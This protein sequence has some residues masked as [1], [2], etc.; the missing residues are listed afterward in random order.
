MGRVL[1]LVLILI[2]QLIYTLPCMWLM[3]R[4]KKPSGSARELNVHSL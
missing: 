4:L 2:T 1:K 3:K